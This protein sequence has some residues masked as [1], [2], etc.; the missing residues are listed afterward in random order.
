MNFESV[1]SIAAIC[2]AVAA[3]FIAAICLIGL[4]NYRTALK[5]SA[6]Q[7][8]RLETLLAH[9][10][11]DA[12]MI[13]QKF[14]DHTRRLAWLEKRARQPKS[15][16]EDKLVDDIAQISKPNISERRHRVLTLYSRGQD[17]QTI[18]ATLGMLHGEVELII[19]LNQTN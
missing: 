16:D 9:H 19:D 15:L 12:E 4:K 5:S 10:A 17:A 14:S 2:L 11:D 6:Q 7:I 1:I 18:A 8:L 3:I 13:S